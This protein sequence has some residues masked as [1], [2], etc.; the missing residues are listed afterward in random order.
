MSVNRVIRHNV[1]QNRG[2]RH[3]VD[4]TKTSQ[5]SSQIENRNKVSSQAET[6]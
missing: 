5:A 3:I 1:K 4:W 6:R 2:A